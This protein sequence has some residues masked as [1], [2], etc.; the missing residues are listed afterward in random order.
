[1]REEYDETFMSMISPLSVKK[2]DGFY[3]SRKGLAL[4]QQAVEIK[5]AL[6]SGQGRA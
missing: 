4:S 6:L 1:V 5:T 2:P 3:Q